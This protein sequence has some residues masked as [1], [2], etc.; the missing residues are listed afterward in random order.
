MNLL[1]KSDEE[2]DWAF[3]LKM[4]TGQSNETFPNKFPK[5]NQKHAG[6]S[7]IGA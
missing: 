6:N 4:E 7:R 1:L 3:F 5:K 2:T